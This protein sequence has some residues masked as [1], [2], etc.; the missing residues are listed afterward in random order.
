MS[1][2]ASGAA[3][4]SLESPAALFGSSSGLGPSG[5]IRWPAEVSSTAAAEEEQN[6]LDLDL[7]DE[8]EDEDEDAF[9]QL[10]EEF[11]ASTLAARDETAGDGAYGSVDVR[12]TK[13]NLSLVQTEFEEDAAAA[14][15]EVGG[16]ETPPRRP[17]E[18]LIL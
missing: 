11:Q 1:G 4:S 15:E 16:D 10:V 17:S 5:L 8:D 9:R 2:R 12:T 6:N 3:E 13:L 14:E 18:I 7:E